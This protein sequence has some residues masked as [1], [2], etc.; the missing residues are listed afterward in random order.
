MTTTDTLTPAGSFLKSEFDAQT[1]Y[2]KK[3]EDSGF[4]YGVVVAGAFV[5]GMRD[6]GYKSNATAL[7]ELIDNAYQ[8]GAAKV[9]IWMETAK[10][11]NVSQL[12]IIDDG[13]GMIRSAIRLAML[14]G[15]THRENSRELFGRF[16][17][18]LPSAC[19]SIGQCFTVYSKTDGADSWYRC[20]FDLEEVGQDG[21]RDHHGQIVMPMPEPAELPPWIVQAI[22]HKN[23]FGASNLDHGTI[24]IISKIDELKPST[25]TAAARGFKE[26]FGLTYRN[27]CGTRPITVQGDKVTPIDPLFLTPGAWAFD[28]DDQRAVEL[29]PMDFDME[30]KETGE[31]GHITIRFSEM[32]YS[33]LR[34][35]PGQAKEKGERFTPRGRV[36]EQNAGIMVLRAGRQ[37]DVVTSDRGQDTGGIKSKFYVQTD[38]RT[39]AVELNFSPVLDDEFSVTTSKQS[40]KMSP[41]I[42][43]ML[44][45]KGVFATIREMRN[46]Y[47]TERKKHKKAK[48][49]GEADEPHT[50]E[51]AMA[52]S[53]SKNRRDKADPTQEERSRTGYEKEKQRRAEAS[54]VD[55]AAIDAA[56]QQEVR[57]KPWVVDFEDLPAGSPFFR[58]EPVG[59]QKRLFINRGHRFFRDVYAGPESNYANQV[60][61]EVMLFILGDC[62]H[63]GSDELLN[64][65]QSERIEWSRRM[66]NALAEVE[67]IDPPAE[68]PADEEDTA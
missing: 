3:V 11:N 38:D 15:G 2:A 43:K 20:T 52:R 59:G 41:R 57:E 54:G 26:T 36:R 27:F 33:Y 46:R 23:N 58:F 12:A 19:V 8:A 7:N 55:P 65:Y 53:E 66:T 1:E 18:G 32:P 50:S 24:V 17:F 13:H 6:V 68:A 4:N 9:A 22:E 61:W 63:S 62:E 40:I 14:W 30:N 28:Y 10:Q 25:A 37:L 45:E 48:Q 5:R 47:D 31:K 60:A 49:S 21:Y 67:L 44:E 39:W 34:R 35:D 42:W 29:P 16:G 51:T 64:F 56:L